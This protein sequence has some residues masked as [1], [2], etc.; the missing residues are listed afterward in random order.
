[1]NGEN[2]YIRPPTAGATT[3]PGTHRLITRYAKNAASAR[4][5]VMTR[6]YV[7]VVPKSA[8]MGQSSVTTSAVGV[9]HRMSVPVG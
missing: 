5:S 6:S 8:V 1:M 2:P 4:L 7:T 9:L 3:P